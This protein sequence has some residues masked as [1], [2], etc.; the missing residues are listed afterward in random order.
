M[1]SAGWE[2]HI[3]HKTSTAAAAAAAATFGCPL[4]PHCLEGIPALVSQHP[5]GSTGA[6]AFSAPSTCS[7]SATADTMAASAAWRCL[8]LAAAAARWA[9]AGPG[10][11]RAH[12][13][14]PQCQTSSRSSS[15]RS[16]GGCGGS[17]TRVQL[18]DAAG[19]NFS[20]GSGGHVLFCS[21]AERRRVMLMNKPLPLRRFGHTH[22]SAV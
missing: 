8:W 18:L 3:A 6:H 2:T 22:A 15:S 4:L 13:A 11:T 14:D 19:D 9:A 17:Q 7:R 1:A 20:C 5:P 12:T 16:C 21:Q 10:S